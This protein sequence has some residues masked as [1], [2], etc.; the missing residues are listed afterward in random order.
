MK[1]VQLSRGLVALV[2]DEDYERVIAG[3]PW[4]AYT[5]RTN[6]YGRHSLSETEQVVMHRFITGAN[7]VDH[8][9]GNG[10]DNRRANLRPTDHAHNLRNQRLQ[11]RSKSGYKGVTANRDKW[12][13]QIR[14]NG[15][16][17]YLGLFVRPEDAAR[18]YDAA[19]IELFGEFARPNFPQEKS[20]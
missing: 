17:R 10:L 8:I 11:A 5:N 12:R 1:E 7:Y 15:R 9:N 13:A 20:A 3:G 2:D 18:A 4:H 16:D 6:T 19:A 14:L